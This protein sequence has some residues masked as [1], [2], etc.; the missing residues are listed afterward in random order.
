MKLKSTSVQRSL[1]RP[2]DM[3]H[4][5]LRPIDMVQPLNEYQKAEELI[6]QEML[7]MLHHDALTDPTLNQCG[8]PANVKKP[9][10]MSNLKPLFVKKHKSYLKENGFE[11]FTQDEIKQVNFFIS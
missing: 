6:K 8:I 2:S 5:I 9:S 1:P 11:T 4:N 7:I 10:T 3:N